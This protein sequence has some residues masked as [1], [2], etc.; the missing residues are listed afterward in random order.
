MVQSVMMDEL[1]DRQKLA[2]LANSMGPEARAK[3]EN[4]V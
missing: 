3:I 2:Q 1:L 4:K